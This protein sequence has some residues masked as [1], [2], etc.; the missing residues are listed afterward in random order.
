MLQLTIEIYQ[1]LLN[2]FSNLLQVTLGCALEIGP[3]W[4]HKFHAQRTDRRLC[5]EVSLRQIVFS[6]HWRFRAYVRKKDLWGVEK[7]IS[8]HE[9]ARTD[10]DFFRSHM[11]PT[12]LIS[13]LLLKIALR[14]SANKPQPIEVHRFEF[15]FYQ[16]FLLS[17]SPPFYSSQPCNP[18]RFFCW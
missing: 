10:L 4:N 11:S 9:P 12:P 17:V 14:R 16:T 18:W 7:E 13:K 5:V 8:R 1:C 2:Q 3:M 15:V 6:K